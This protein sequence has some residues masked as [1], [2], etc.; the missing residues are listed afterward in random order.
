M[1]EATLI[2]EVIILTYHNIELVAVDSLPLL[3]LSA[4]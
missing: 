4:L 2:G 3:M 1:K